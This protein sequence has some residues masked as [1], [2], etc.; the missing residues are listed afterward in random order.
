MTFFLDEF[1]VSDVES[2]THFVSFQKMS[3]RKL[4]ASPENLDA[5]VCSFLGLANS[6]IFSE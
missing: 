3:I 6:L 4:Q 2:V 5:L 1:V